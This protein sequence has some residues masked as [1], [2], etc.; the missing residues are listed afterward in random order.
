ML[1][2]SIQV[3]VVNFLISALITAIVYFFKKSVRHVNPL[4]LFFISSVGSFLGS[5]LAIALPT[6]D[7]VIIQS[8][9]ITIPGISLSVL[10]IFIWARGSKSRS[11]F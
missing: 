7:E 6:V 11:Y 3:L 9:L 4:V 2:L 10:F 8:I 5:I 1:L